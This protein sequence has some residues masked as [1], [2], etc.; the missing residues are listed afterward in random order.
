MAPAAPTRR[1]GAGCADTK[2]WRRLRRHEGMAPA[3]PTR[4]YGAGCA[5]KKIWRRLRRQEDM[6]PAAPTRRYGAGC[7]GRAPW[8]H[9]LGDPPWMAASPPGL[10]AAPARMTARAPACWKWSGFR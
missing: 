10:F 4:R 7:A 5:D 1:H 6:A 8:G 9:D 3:A 2:A